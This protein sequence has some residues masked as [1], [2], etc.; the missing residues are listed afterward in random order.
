MCIRDSS[1]S[2]CK[3]EQNTSF[4]QSDK[5]NMGWKPVI[6]SKFIIFMLKNIFCYWSP[7]LPLMA[8]FV[9]QF[10]FQHKYQNHGVSCSY[11]SRQRP[12]F[13]T[14]YLFATY[15][16]NRSAFEGI[17]ISSTQRYSPISTSFMFCFREL[18][19]GWYKNITLNKAKN[20]PTF[21]N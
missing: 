19:K 6:K 3:A 20:V 16:F 12:W 8:K 10:L 17:I 7:M 18:T 14:Y 4:L 15:C 5:Q 11:L 9:L 2:H 1:W 21:K 13:R